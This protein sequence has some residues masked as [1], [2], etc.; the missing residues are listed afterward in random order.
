[1]SVAPHTYSNKLFNKKVLII[2]PLP[3]PMGGVSIHIERVT[4]TLK[5]QECSVYHFDSTM[6]LR[7]R[8]FMLY[9]L[10]ELAYMLWCWPDE[11]H[12]H[13]LYL[14]N[15]RQELWLL[16]MAKKLFCIRLVLIEHDCRHLY[17]RTTAFKR[18]LKR[19][20]DRADLMV[21][22]GSKTLESYK[23]AQL[24]TF[25]MRCESAFLPPDSASRT[26]TQDEYPQT[27]LAFIAQKKPLIAATAFAPVLIDGKDL[28]GFDLALALVH[29]LK[30]EFPDLGLIIM[31][32]RTDTDYAQQVF[33][34]IADYQ[35]ESHV[36]MLSGNYRAWPLI[37]KSDL[38]I[39]PTRSDGMSV[40]IEEALYFKGPVVASD[41]CER[42]AGVHLFKAGDSSDC[43]LK[44]RACLYEQSHIN[45]KR[46][47]LYAQS[48]R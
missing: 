4:H 12:F 19:L 3:P 29:A 40:S 42:P 34:L 16:R 9:W 18:A 36:Y 11:I 17:K 30:G 14:C 37:E 33:A 1:M 21:L 31:V 48:T 25:S 8:L 41:V 47:H 39:R 46:Y 22:I 28:Y 45:P 26:L 35:L 38:F 24:Y 23:D 44:V 43:I 15:V 7:Y 5:N 32:A 13:T 6:E 20:I 10:Y 2:G 27:V